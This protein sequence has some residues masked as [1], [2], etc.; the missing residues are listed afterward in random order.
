MQMYLQT[1]GLGNDK[2]IE[3]D[4]VLALGNDTEEPVCQE[5]V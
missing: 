2:L 4:S 3:G 5:S 1:V